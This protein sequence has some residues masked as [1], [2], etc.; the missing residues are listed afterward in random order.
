[1]QLVIEI[2]HDFKY[3]LYHI[4]RSYAS[5]IQYNTYEIIHDIFGPSGNDPKKNQSVTKE[6]E[7]KR[8][9]I[10]GREK[11]DML[12]RLSEHV[13]MTS[14]SQHV[15]TWGS[16]CIHPFVIC[17]CIYVYVPLYMCI[18]IYI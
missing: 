7:Q 13:C 12:V 18:L 17:V 6:V 3:R 1:M 8:P 15:T 11:L 16:F 5:M 14:R 4:P 10:L 2:L 9:I